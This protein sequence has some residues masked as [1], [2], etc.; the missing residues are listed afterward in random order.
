MENLPHSCIKSRP[1]AFFNASWLEIDNFELT[2]PRRP[3]NPESYPRNAK[4]SL[5]IRYHR[6]MTNWRVVGEVPDSD[7]DG[8]D[9][10]ELPDQ[11]PE[12]VPNPIP[13]AAEKAQ[14]SHN[15]D[16]DIWA[17]PDSPPSPAKPHRARFPTST[18]PSDNS[19]G[20]ARRPS[21][22]VAQPTQP[23]SNLDIWE[24]PS[25][26]PTQR[27][28]KPPAAK[29]GFLPHVNQ[30]VQRPITPDAS[31][32]CMVDG[33]RGMAEGGELA[34]GLPVVNGPPT[35]QGTSDVHVLAAFQPMTSPLSSPLGS[36]QSCCSENPEPP[37]DSSP[38]QPRRPSPARNLGVDDDDLEITRQTAV[39]L[40]RSLR[41]RKPIQQHP[42]LLENA[43]YA[44][45]MRSHG[46]KPIKVRMAEAEAARRR[47]Q[48]ED[49][50]EQEYEA[51]ESQERKET[52]ENTPLL[53][54]NDGGQ[55][56][57]A[58]SPSPFRTSPP[59]IAPRTSSQPVTGNHTPLTTFSD[60]DENELPTLSQ[61]LNEPGNQRVRNLKRQ[62]SKIV[63]PRRKRRAIP[64]SSQASSPPRMHIPP[65][66]IWDLSSSPVRS[67][68][69]PNIESEILGNTSP[70]VLQRKSTPSVSSSA[71]PSSL[72]LQRR[73]ATIAHVFAEEDDG[74]RSDS[75]T[76]S[77]SAS[78]GSETDTVRQNVKRIRGV[79][80]ASWLR[81]DQ[82][83]KPAAIR[84]L[85][86]SPEP[87]APAPRRGVALP[88]Q[89]T[90]KRPSATQFPFDEFDDS[91][92]EPTKEPAL[93]ENLPAT[94]SVITIYEDD[95]A[96]SVVEEDVIDHMLLGRKKRQ[97]SPTATRKAKRQKRDGVSDHPRQVRQPRITEV[98]NR[99]KSASA[100]ST[101]KSRSAKGQRIGG[102][103][104]S[105]RRNLNKK[106]A[107][108]PRLSILDVIEPTAPKFLKIAAR[109][110]KK[111]PN[112]G[113]TSPS[114]KLISLASR[115]DNIDALS[116]LR[117]WKTGKTQQRATL[118]TPQQP[119]A[120]K[121]VL[122]EISLNPRS[123]PAQPISRLV[124]TRPQR[125]AR[126]GNLNDFV[127]VD[128]EWRQSP[129]S[130]VGPSKRKALRD[131]RLPSF[132][133]AQLETEGARLDQGRL[134][135]HKRTLDTLYRV[136]NI[137]PPPVENIS[138]LLS[139]PPSPPVLH[140]Q[141]P[142][143]DEV[144]A[145]ESPRTAKEVERLARSKPRFRKKSR[146]RQVDVDSPEYAHSNDPLPAEVT[147]FAIGEPLPQL[148]DKLRGLG[149]YGTIY[150]HHFEVFPLDRGSFFHESTLLGRGCIR[151]AID[152][153]LSAKTQHHRTAVSFV[154]D[155]QTLRWG[156]WDDKVSS[157]LG[158]VI[159][160]VTEKLSMQDSSDNQCSG[161]A[162]LE[163]VDFVLQ[164]ALDSMSVRDS[165]AEAAFVSRCLEVFS[166]FVARFDSFNWSDVSRDCRRMRV[167]AGVR[168]SVVIMAA[169][170]L[171]R[172]A[173]RITTHCFQV[174][175]LLQKCAAATIKGLLSC[176]LDD[177]RTLYGNL[178]RLSFR[179][180]G[181]RS[182]QYLAHGWV[183]MMR[184]LEHARIPRGSFW[185]IAQSVMT[186]AAVVSGSDAQAF[187]KLWEDMFTLL[188]LGE[189]DEH[190]VLILGSRR[191][192][193]LEGWMLPQ[194]LLKRVFEVYKSKTRQ[195]PSFN[196][197]VR[198]LVARCHYLIQQWGWYRCTAIIGTIFDF[199]GSEELMNLRNE[200]VYR[201]PRF[202]EE[203]TGNPSLSVEPEDR[204]FHVFTKVV[205]LT[206]QR[207]KQLER[208]KD[209]N[210]LVARILP[211]HDR[212]YLKEDAIHQRDLAALRNHHD[213]L[214]SLFWAAPPE[215]R[216]KLHL[217]EKLVMP[218][219][220]HKEAILIN[221]RA[222]S[223]L[224]RFIISSSECGA[225][226]RPFIVW[227][228]NVFN[229]VL[230]QYL[231]AASDIEQQFRNL[232]SDI[233]RVSSAVKDEMIAKNKATAMDLLHFS[234]K[235][236]LDVLRNAANFESTISAFNINQLQKIFTALDF[237]AAAFDWGV[238]RIG[239]ETVEHFLC[240][241]DQAT[242][243]QYSTGVGDEVNAQQAEEAILLFNEK[244]VRDFFWMSRTVIGLDVQRAGKRA[245]QLLCTEKAV[246]LAARVAARF[247][248]NGLTVSPIARPHARGTM[249]L[250]LASD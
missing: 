176:G 81:L 56:G 207:L 82:K 226:F 185:D 178:Q 146:P 123:H 45:I 106:T 232:S 201:S 124:P 5:W 71:L 152:P 189:V 103:G 130:V 62:G 129:S 119:V 164:Y 135:I 87:P 134:R 210:N 22:P 205:G 32:G 102:D 46:V 118:P 47:A 204:C 186:T 94:A 166:S 197:Y 239:L 222:W 104:A 247:V 169:L 224:G 77:P 200:E 193:P 36:L 113:R 148:Q 55:D 177:L 203:L 191:D 38:P 79:L 58:L 3:Q 6:I 68:A 54:D 11:N 225:E 61:L 115:R 132:R 180:R 214:C 163:A 75:D 99:S 125:L 28:T 96:A 237:H 179:E 63:A 211:N 170:S 17:I 158:I 44:N 199:F 149:P 157:E 167:E 105:N 234:V 35:T 194:R 91:D 110:V 65:P 10:F 182:D 66:I 219:R 83:R 14:D 34:N 16:V 23:R 120:R 24:P 30:Q 142:E 173:Q 70:A 181:I 162:A 64:S 245:A 109:A 141:L 147:P 48:E 69:L 8:L 25:S 144:L 153:Q 107:T 51:E 233:R 52:E 241:L 136:R 37:I 50:Q 7:D 53:F 2:Q 244:L 86:K 126:Q 171:S 117:D 41:P 238:L 159:D 192:N 26:S 72:R 208:H 231:S 101:S 187:E 196:E 220:A 20:P 33:Y 73:R 127:I 9:D 39:R 111:K 165:D 190:G 29:P 175:S 217:I 60:D 183:V 49:S 131:Y 243:E 116:T 143:V 57:L 100:A 98:L 59:G 168:I 19:N 74:A 12:D 218:A 227:S 156:V 92:D 21:T 248:K 184:V 213:L 78:S 43:Q 93:P 90:P 150:T 216:P 108:A 240:Q 139:A 27:V 67:P 89:T 206:I 221:L 122:E 151:K 174:E 138:D 172:S 250:I 154:L 18:K 128:A 133:P 230:D 223:Q 137:S 15:D 160:W 97:S 235:T 88:K 209:I 31:K 42:Y 1:A 145:A 228:N 198:A 161:N 95:D 112:H 229:Q 140:A 155:G 188:P 84:N 236:S 13:T 4:E 202:L 80:P 121:A 85:R 40:E 212:Q 246:T 242:E 76:S 249:I 114:N 215:L 195:L